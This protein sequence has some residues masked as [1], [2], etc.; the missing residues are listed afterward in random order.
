[1]AART[2]QVVL[3]VISRAFHYRDRNVFHSLFKQYVRPHLEFASPAWFPWLEADKE[4]PKKV[5]KRAVNMISGLKATTCEE[6]LRELGLTTLEE[7]RHQ[8][9]TVQLYKII[10]GKD[11]VNSEDWFQKV[12]G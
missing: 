8:T 2:A 9:D 7:R 12:D 11:M 5:Q 1:M 3:S 6:K 10:T 4:V